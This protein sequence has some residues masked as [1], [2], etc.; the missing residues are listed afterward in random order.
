MAVAGVFGEVTAMYTPILAGVMAVTGTPV[1]AG[2]MAVAGVL[3]EVLVRCVPALPVSQPALLVERVV[4]TLGP[5]T[6]ARNPAGALRSW[7]EELGQHR[8]EPRWY[9]C[10]APDVGSRGQSS[11][12]RPENQAA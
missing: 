4:V 8:F 10:Q 2:V 9:G 5:R 6:P 1:L 7:G 12:C 3:V 11:Q